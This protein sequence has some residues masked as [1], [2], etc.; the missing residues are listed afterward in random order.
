MWKRGGCMRSFDLDAAKR[1]KKFVY[2]ME[3]Y[4]TMKQ[5]WPMD[6]EV[7]E[8]G[9]VAVTEFYKNLMR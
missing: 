5:Y 2:V 9:V 3:K 4:M 7:W 1:R 8:N 6:L